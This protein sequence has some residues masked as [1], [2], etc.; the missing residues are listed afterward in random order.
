MIGDGWGNYEYRFGEHDFEQCRLNG[1]RRGGRVSTG[2]L[3]DTQIPA[4]DEANYRLTEFKNRRCI[5]TDKQNM[6]TEWPSG[7]C[8]GQILGAC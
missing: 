7:F 3:K 6:V 2:H 4:C 5:D 1:I 8:P